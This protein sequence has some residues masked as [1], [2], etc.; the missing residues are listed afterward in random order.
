[1]YYKNVITVLAVIDISKTHAFAF[2][3]IVNNC[4]PFN[5]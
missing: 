5:C 1:M 2:Y 3:L 4:V